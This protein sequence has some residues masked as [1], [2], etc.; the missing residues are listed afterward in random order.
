MVHL[1][2]RPLRNRGRCTLGRETAIQRMHWSADGWLRT[3]DG[4]GLPFT[5]TAAPALPVHAFPVSPSREEFDS[6]QLPLDFQWLRSPWPDELFSLTERPGHLRLFGRE[7]IG[8]LFRQ[9]LVAR[10]QQSHCFSAITKVE[11]EPEHFQQMAGLVC[12]YNSSKFH[13]FYV[14]HDQTLGKHVRVM[15]CL[16]DQV[17][18][19]AFTSPIA[20]A[21]GAAVQLRVEVDYERLH[22]AYRLDGHDWC[23]LAEQF[24]ASILS[25]EA[26]HCARQS[27][28]HR[29]LCGDVL[30]G[31]GRHLPAG[32]FRL[33]RLPRATFFRAGHDD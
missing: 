13:Y 33:L 1:C 11:F 25:D 4:Q 3:V 22:F 14:S 16:P 5:E 12:Y 24:D 8:S 21:P 27:K 2:G 17:Q 23:W 9:A 30:S 32:G 19:D 29:G 20:I 31:S 18:T 10:R 28:F 15:S 7:S 6:S 26:Q